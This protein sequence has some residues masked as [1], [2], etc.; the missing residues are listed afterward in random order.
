[1]ESPEITGSGGGGGQAPPSSPSAP[2]LPRVLY[3][4]PASQSVIFWTEGW[5]TS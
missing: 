1:M 5:A 3:A 2:A 4:P